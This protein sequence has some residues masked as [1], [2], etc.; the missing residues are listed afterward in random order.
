MRL[1]ADET[2][3]RANSR[4]GGIRLALFT[5]RFAEKWRAAWRDNDRTLIMGA[6]VAITEE[7]LTRAELEPELRDV[8]NPIPA[9]RF[10][11]CTISSIAAAT[12]FSRETT[13]R[14]VGELV[15]E[16]LLV[17][18]ERGRITFREGLFQ[19]DSKLALFHEQLEAVGRLATELLQDGVLKLDSSAKD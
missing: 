15:R 14:K 12:G 1:V 10:A 3:P 17:R 19:E 7:R 9:D 5:L 13:R 2:D 16:G 6:V 11:K 4:R 18:D 8:K